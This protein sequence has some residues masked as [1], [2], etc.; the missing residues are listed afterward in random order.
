MASRLIKRGL[1]RELCLGFG[2]DLS[3]GG[4]IDQCLPHSVDDPV[5]KEL[6]DTLRR[7][8]P[9]LK[10]GM[11]VSE[12]WGDCVGELQ[13]DVT[14]ISLVSPITLRGSRRSRGGSGATKGPPQRMH[15]QNAEA[16]V[17][18]NIDYVAL[19]NKAILDF[20]E[21]GLHDSWAALDAA[22]IAHSGSGANQNE[23]IRPALISS[24]GRTI[25]YFA[26]SAVGSGMRDATGTDV[27]AAASRRSGIALFNV[28]D[29]NT[30]AVVFEAYR[31]Q[32]EALRAEV[33]ISLVVFSVCWGIFSRDGGSAPTVQPA[34]RTFARGLVDAVGA[35]IIYGH[36]TG[37]A[38][39]VE[40][41]CGCPILYSCGTLLADVSTS[42]ARSSSA[43]V[44]T[45]SL[46]FK[47]QIS[48][49]NAVKW[50]EVCALRFSSAPGE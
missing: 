49:L 44:D 19:A 35:N 16:L 26:L 11:R 36:G 34:M 31:A 37:H 45:V 3:L 5:A 27:W 2:G 12:V 6:A 25:A 33:R 14:A 47:V 21:V 46:F 38:L 48:G 50:I 8:H 17:G 41:Y 23:A 18:A 4:C 10:R 1:G 32:L 40:V 20:G 7:Q 13:S 9:L 22:T 43:L 39:G 24:Q 29:E 42:A 15:P 30:H 28:W